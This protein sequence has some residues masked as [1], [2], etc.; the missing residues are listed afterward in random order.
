MSGVRFGGHMHPRH[1]VDWRRS[2]AP[3]DAT[4][5]NKPVGPQLLASAITATLLG[6]SLGL[7]LFYG[8]SSG[9]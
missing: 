3:A 4:R 6:A 7:L 5:G 9:V 1:A 2:A 8:L